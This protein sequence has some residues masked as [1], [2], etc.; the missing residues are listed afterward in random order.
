[1]A[2][3]SDDQRFPIS[4]GFSAAITFLLDKEEPKH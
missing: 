2:L 1:M 3:G 4:V